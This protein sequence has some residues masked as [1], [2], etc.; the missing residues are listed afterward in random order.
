MHRRIEVDI[1]SVE[2]GEEVT[3]YKS[4]VTSG[5]TTL[6][7]RSTSLLAIEDWTTDVVG[8]LV[9]GVSPGSHFLVGEGHPYPTI[10]AIE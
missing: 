10:E 1:T 3:W 4:K 2:D 6:G 5:Q 7:A 8:S 9:L